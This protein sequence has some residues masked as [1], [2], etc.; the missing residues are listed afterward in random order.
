MFVRVGC[1][2]GRQRDLPEWSMSQLAERLQFY[3]KRSNYRS[4]AALARATQAYTSISASYIKQLLGGGRTNP[5]Y[6]KIIA[7]ASAL[8]LSVYETNDLLQ[9]AGYPA[10]P[11]VSY[12]EATPQIRRI[13]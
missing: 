1:D 2:C 10:Q 13:L 3:F 4:L 8:D 6:E 7:L 11:I 12:D 5:A 9:A